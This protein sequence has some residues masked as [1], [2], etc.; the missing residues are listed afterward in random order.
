MSVIECE[1]DVSDCEDEN[2]CDGVVNGG[3][4]AVDADAKSLGAW[5][6][7]GACG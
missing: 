3:G 5:E 1:G 7:G 2:E 6:Q 4:C